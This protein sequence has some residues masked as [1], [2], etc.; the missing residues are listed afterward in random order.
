MPESA[1]RLSA[2]QIVVPRLLRSI[3]GEP[4]EIPGAE[5]VHLQFRRF[6]GCPI[7]NLHLLSFA[8]RH[9]EIAAAGVREVVL[10]HSSETELRPFVDHFPFDVVADP[11]KKLYA[12]FGV[13]WSYR[14]MLDPRSWP[15][16]LRGVLLSLMET[17]GK[18]RPIPPINPA[19]GRW[20]LPADFLIGRDGRVIACK[21]GVHADDQWSVDELL[22]RVKREPSRA[23]A[24][25]ARGIPDPTAG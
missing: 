15:A 12:A 8:R 13:E 2:G 21:Y 24:R 3:T 18:H 4:V 10:F 7:C 22:A 19:G 25:D 5:I 1:A 16:I 17:I 11:N 23:A 6:A 14:A 9:A 20:G